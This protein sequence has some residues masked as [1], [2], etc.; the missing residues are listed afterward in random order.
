MR[1]LLII[2]LLASTACFGQVPE[3]PQSAMYVSYQPFD[4]GIGFRLDGYV[5]DHVGLYTSGSYGTSG[6]YKSAGLEGHMK[7]TLGA[8]IPFHRDARAISS[9][10]IGGS[11]H[12]VSEIPDLD[13]SDYWAGDRIYG[14]LSFEL[15]IAIQFSRVAISFRTDVLRWEPCIDVGVVIGEK[16]KE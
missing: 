9:M 15:G 10:V 7:L 12:H 14:P 2:L 16:K 4:H 8:L 11:Y 5:S 1:E 3:R 6:L 13:P